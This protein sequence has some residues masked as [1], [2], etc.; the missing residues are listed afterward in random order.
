M[1]I[2]KKLEEDTKIFSFRD[3]PNICIYRGWDRGRVECNIHFCKV[4]LLKDIV[5]CT[6]PHSSMICAFESNFAVA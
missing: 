6:F 2:V 1:Q 5:F 3:Q 4:V